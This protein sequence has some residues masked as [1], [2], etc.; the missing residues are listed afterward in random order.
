MAGYRQQYNEKL[1]C[2]TDIQP[3]IESQAQAIYIYLLSPL[4]K[5]C[6]ILQVREGASNKILG[7][8]ITEMPWKINDPL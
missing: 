7:G 8:Q 2:D 6:W 3:Q 1:P 5:S 4:L